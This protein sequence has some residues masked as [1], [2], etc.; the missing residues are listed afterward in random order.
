MKKILFTVLSCVLC[1]CLIQ[2]TSAYSSDIDKIYENEIKCSI[3]AG[4]G[5]AENPY[6]LDNE[7]APMFT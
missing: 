4:D 5:S 6:I 1:I 7:S 2:P 3:I